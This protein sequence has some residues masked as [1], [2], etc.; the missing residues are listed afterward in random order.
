MPVEVVSEVVDE[1]ALAQLGPDAKRLQYGLNNGRLGL[2]EEITRFLVR[3]PGEEGLALDPDRIFVINGPQQAFY[4]AI[5]VLS[6]LGD[7]IFVEK[8]TYF[9]FLEGLK[10]LPVQP[11]SMR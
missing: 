7:I 9:I 10:G 11:M 5:Q 3:Y 4:L 2:S 6:D 8:P 1:L